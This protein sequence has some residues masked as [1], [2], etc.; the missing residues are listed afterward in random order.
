LGEPRDTKKP[1]RAAEETQRAAEIIAKD[2]I[3]F[4]ADLCDLFSATLSG[5]KKCIR[6]LF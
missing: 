3:I 1:Q 4:S 6:I 2:H 5:L